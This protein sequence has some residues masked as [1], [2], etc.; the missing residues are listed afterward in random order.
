MW[1]QLLCT[2]ATPHRLAAERSP[3]GTSC[4]LPRIGGVCPQGEPLSSN[5][6]KQRNL[7]LIGRKPN[8][9]EIFVYLIIIGMCCGR[10]GS[11]GN[12]TSGPALPDGG[13]RFARQARPYMGQGRYLPCGRRGGF[14]IRPLL[15]ARCLLVQQNP[16]LTAPGTGLRLCPRYAPRP[17]RHRCR[18]SAGRQG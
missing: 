15:S 2:R 7:P 16:P 11:C 5:I 12:C 17:A 6:H 9:R 8:R 4:H 13:H 3:S 10:I 14:Y 1:M 18:S